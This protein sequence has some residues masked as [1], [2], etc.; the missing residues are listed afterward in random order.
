MPLNP[1]LDTLNTMIIAT[2]NST[3]HLEKMSDALVKAL[4]A[5]NLRRAPG[6]FGPEGEKD[7]DWL[8]IDCY[9]IAVHLM[10]SDIR[11]ILN[12]EDHWAPGNIRPCL[13]DVNSEKEYEKQFD[14]LLEKY[15]VPYEYNLDKQEE[16]NVTNKIDPKKVTILAYE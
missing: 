3:R 8:Y 7:D 5:R 4:K 2:G 14:L 15:P 12:L 1:P 6:M 13:S 16:I 11:K 10:L 9:N